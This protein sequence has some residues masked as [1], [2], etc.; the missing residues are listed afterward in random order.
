MM[1]GFARP[2]FP[3][4]SFWPVV[5]AE[6]A[7]LGGRYNRSISYADRLPRTDSNLPLLYPAGYRQPICDAAKAQKTD[8]LWLHAI[9]W[10][11]SKYN[12]ASR[13][14]AAARGLMQFIPETANAVASTIGLGDVTLEQ[15]PRGVYFRCG[16]GQAYLHDSAVAA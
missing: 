5:A 11:E 2:F 13:S 4:R 6:I 9:I 1:E 10:Q 16:P 14:G 7:F 15:G 8:P 3:G 12:P